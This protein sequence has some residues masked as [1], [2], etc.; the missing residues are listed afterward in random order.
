[1]IRARGADDVA[2]LEYLMKDVEIAA[3]ATNPAA[4]RLLWDVCQTP[5]YRKDMSD[6]H[7]RLLGHLYRYLATGPGVIPADYVARALGPFRPQ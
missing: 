5:D 3:L 6:G 2:A 4:V 1:M 7:P